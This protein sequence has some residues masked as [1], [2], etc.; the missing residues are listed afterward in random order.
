MHKH[1]R[2]LFIDHLIQ[3]IIKLKLEGYKVALAAD[4]NENSVDRKLSKAL[5]QIGLI[6][7]FCRKF[8][9]IEPVFHIRDRE[10]IDSV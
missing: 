7:A 5:K 2:K 10:Q 6:E 4:A 1:P 3:F 8:Q 9:I